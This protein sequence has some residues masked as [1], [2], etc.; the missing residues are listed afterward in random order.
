MALAALA[1][2]GT[3]LAQTG[4]N[5]TTRVMR[6]RGTI[7]RRHLLFSTLTLALAAALAPRAASAQ[8]TV[9]GFGALRVGESS[10]QPSFGGSIS[11][12]VAP[13]VQIFGEAGR[14]DNVL[15]PLVSDLISLSPVGVGVEALYGEAG[16]RVLTSPRS[17]VTGYVEGSAGIASLRPTVSG[18]SNGVIGGITNASL[19]LLQRT[20]PMAGVG[21]GVLLNAGPVAVDL[22]YRY[23]KLFADGPVERAL[24]LGQGL[25]VSQ[26]RV[27]VGIRF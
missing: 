25:S 22:G 16:L 14:I 20:E 7:M 8:T 21:G 9:Q 10:T 3:A 17:A 4:V 15:P 1:E 23:K 13:A 12:N 26:V 11:R 27:G 6:T 2:A 19:T 24:S 5:V 18:I